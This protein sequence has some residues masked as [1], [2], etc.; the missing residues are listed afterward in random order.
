MV[1]ETYTQ[2]DSWSLSSITHGEYSWQK[3]RQKVT[4]ENQH[5][6]II[7]DDIREDAERIKIRRFIYKKA[8]SLMTKTNDHANN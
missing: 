7:T 8:N 2:K 3:A 4:I 1:F 6:L 5:A